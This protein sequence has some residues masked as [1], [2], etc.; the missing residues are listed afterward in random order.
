[1]VNV[2]NPVIKAVA[3]EHIRGIYI[4]LEMSL[5][6]Y[7]NLLKYGPRCMHGCCCVT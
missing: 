6:Q 5:K 1:M 7:K 4:E 2:E 3:V